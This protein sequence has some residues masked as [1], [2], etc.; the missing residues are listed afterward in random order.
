M[1]HPVPK[2]PRDKVRRVLFI[3][4]GIV[5]STS[6]IAAFYVGWNYQRL[7]I[8][9]ANHFL[10][11]YQI[12]VEHLSFTPLTLTHWQVPLV[13]LTV[14]KSHINITGLDIVLDQDAHLWSLNIADLASLSAKKV[15]VQL[16]PS[17]LRYSSTPNNDPGPTMALDFTA[18]PKISIGQ[19]TFTVKGISAA[20]LNMTLAHMTL[21]KDGQ[22]SSK[23]SYNQH[24]V[25]SLDAQLLATEW[26]AKTQLNLTQLQ[27][28]TADIHA[29]E[30]ALFPPINNASSHFSPQQGG[31]LLVPLY[32]LQAAIEAQQIDLNAT[33]D[34]TITLALKSGQLQSSHL[35][36][37]LQIRLGALAGLQLTPTRM[38]SH[39]NNSAITKKTNGTSLLKQ[40]GQLAF[41]INGHIT[42]LTLTVQPFDLPIILNQQ[43]L[44][45]TTRM[46][47]SPQIVSFLNNLE[48]T[49][50]EDALAHLYQVL[51]PDLNTNQPKIQPNLHIKV[52][53]PLVYQFKSQ[54]LL[55]SK[56]S[57]ALE[58]TK[59]D[60]IIYLQNINYAPPS[61][62]VSTTQQ[63]DFQL[64]LDWQL[65]ASH[66][67]SITIN[68][69]WPTLKK[70]PYNISI[71]NA[72]LV[73]QGDLLVNKQQGKSAYTVTV[74][75]Q[76]S[77]QTQGIKI[78]S[79]HGNRYINTSPDQKLAVHI[80]ETKLILASTAKYHFAD[81]KTNISIPTLHYQ[82]NSADL[83]QQ[84]S[85]KQQTHYQLFVDAI[86]VELEKAFLYSSTQTIRT[87][88]CLN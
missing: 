84:S 55:L 27:A 22:F 59:L 29:A 38:V 32:Q 58:N 43:P 34:S 79:N 23:I 75:P 20:K 80:A 69:L 60:T 28:L 51:L 73:L 68:T 9:L 72:E 53:S 14:N 3:L 70:L 49:P 81:G 64:Q 57:V 13:A 48:D 35:L 25:F 45:K 5:L 61:A 47:I 21:N 86:E 26:R 18:L 6:L 36:S 88:L 62:N 52:G 42:D 67:H 15:K 40:P 4:L 16:D 83:S 56:L 78:T 85:D 71:N 44:S 37:Q 17:V 76:S 46:P 82:V 77:L 24:F 74:Q 50:L 11:P 12:Q 1:Q 87:L 63:N 19:T 54:S 10:Q 65:L 39:N 2:T 8:K 66:Q 7:T 41:N 30:M 31:S 33:L